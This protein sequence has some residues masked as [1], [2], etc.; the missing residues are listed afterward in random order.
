MSGDDRGKRHVCDGGKRPIELRD[1]WA[2]ASGDCPS[3]WARADSAIAWARADSASAGVA[4]ASGVVFSAA[5]CCKAT[6]TNT[7]TNTNTDTNVEIVT[8]ERH[9]R[10]PQCRRGARA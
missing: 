1:R 7:N 4:A 6:T 5:V 8:C 2:R 10:H 3:A 9:E